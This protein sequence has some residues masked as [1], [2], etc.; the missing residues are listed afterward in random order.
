V[1]AQKSWKLFL[2]KPFVLLGVNPYWLDQT[3]AFW[4]AVFK[5]AGVLH[6][7]AHNCFGLVVCNTSQ[8]FI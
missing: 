5:A 8:P 4:A 1:E 2:D 7:H 3:A 6:Y